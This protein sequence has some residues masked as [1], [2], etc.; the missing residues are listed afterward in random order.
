MSLRTPPSST[1]GLVADRPSP[2]V[3]VAETTPQRDEV[4][5]EFGPAADISADLALPR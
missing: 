2:T 1:R 4:P 5:A 3:S